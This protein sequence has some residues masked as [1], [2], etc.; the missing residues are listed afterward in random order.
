MSEKTDR[1]RELVSDVAAAYFSN[2]HVSPGEIPQVVAQ[3]ASSLKA[4]VQNGEDLI[5]AA[6][7]PVHPRAKLTPAQIRSSIKPDGLISFE[8]GRTYKTLRRHLSSRGMT[9]AQYCEKWGLPPDYPMVAS[10]LSEMRS[11]LARTM[12]LGRT[13]TTSVKHLGSV[14]QKRNDKFG[15]R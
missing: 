10:S 15:H 5:H 3:I 7:E 13:V 9:P 14:Q 12:R 1:L 4:V 2:S 11:E 6:V 8:D